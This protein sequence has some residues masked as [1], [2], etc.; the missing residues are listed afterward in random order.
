M[1][2]YLENRILSNIFNQNAN[3]LYNHNC[4][5]LLNDRVNKRHSVSQFERINGGE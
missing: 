5:T 2:Q 3:Y 1:L 4:K